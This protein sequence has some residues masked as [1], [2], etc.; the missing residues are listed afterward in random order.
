[1]TNFLYVS[2]FAPGIAGRNSV[3][4]LASSSRRDLSIFGFEPRQQRVSK[5]SEEVI[6]PLGYHEDPQ[7]IQ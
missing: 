4:Q 1:M 2:I 3:R 6:H 5:I 7:T